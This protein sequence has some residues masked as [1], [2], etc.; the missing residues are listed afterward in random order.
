MTEEIMIYCRRCLSNLDSDHPADIKDHMARCGWDDCDR[1]E[2]D[3]NLYHE[4]DPAF[5][6]IVT[7]KKCKGEGIIKNSETFL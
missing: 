3:G 1:C 7:C 2:G 6:D 4:G 5:Y